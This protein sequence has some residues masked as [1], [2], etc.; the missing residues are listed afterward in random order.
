VANKI[1]RYKEHTFMKPDATTNE[2]PMDPKENPVGTGHLPV[3]GEVGVGETPYHDPVTIDTNDNPDATG[4]TS[5]LPPDE[6]E[7][8]S[9]ERQL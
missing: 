6:P 7:T 5:N 1:A 8:P 9:P 3:A 4:A 2:Y